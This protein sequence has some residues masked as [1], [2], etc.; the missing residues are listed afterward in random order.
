MLLF[1]L[2]KLTVLLKISGFS[3]NYVRAIHYETLVFWL[4]IGTPLSKSKST[5]FYTFNEALHFEQNRFL[6]V[7]FYASYS[8]VYKLRTQ[9]IQDLELSAQRFELLELLFLAFLLD[10]I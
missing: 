7:A 9:I 2:V 1:F 8:L 5:F 6:V 4:Y 10:L 3:L